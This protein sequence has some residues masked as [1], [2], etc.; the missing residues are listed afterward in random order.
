MQIS[1]S[2]VL[3][4]R[5]KDVTTYGSTDDS[6]NYR[7]FAGVTAAGAVMVTAAVVVAATLLLR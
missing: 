6:I 1:E 2:N 4:S 7:L 3:V 5:V